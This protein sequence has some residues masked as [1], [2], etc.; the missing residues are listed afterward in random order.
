MRQMRQYLAYIC[1]K[2]VDHIVHRDNTT[3]LIPATMSTIQHVRIPCTNFCCLFVQRQV[4]VVCATSSIGC[5]CNVKYWLFVQPQV[6][7]VCTTSSIGCLCNVKYCLFLRRQVLVV[8]AT[9]SI[10]CLCNVKY[11][12][13]V[14]RQVFVVCATS[15]IGC[16]MYTCSYI[17]QSQTIVLA[18]ITD[19]TKRL[20][21]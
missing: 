15:S 10:G 12:L 14:P 20:P 13:F 21:S 6:L 8:C 18:Q 4:L 3:F 7:V 17:V 2:Y 11:C 1:G 9:S 19:Y 5:L 16:L